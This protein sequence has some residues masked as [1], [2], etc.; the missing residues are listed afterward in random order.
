MS[1]GGRAR[2]RALLLVAPLAAFMA[3][4]FAWPLAS[5]LGVAVRS[6]AVSTALPRTAAAI[7]EWDGA[8]LPALEV[9]AALVDDLRDVDRQTL[10][11]AVGRLNAAVPGFRSL[12]AGT[13][14]AAREVAGPL[15]LRGVDSR[16][17]EAPFWRAIR[18]EA[19]PLTDRNLLAA[20]DLRRDE[21]GGIERV[22]QG[23]SASWAVLRRSFSIAATITAACLAI[24]LPYAVIAARAAGWRRNAMLLAVLLPLWTSLLVRT[25]AWYILLQE[26]GLIND[27]LRGLGL[28]DA[29]LPLIF[30]RLGVVVAMTHVLLPFMV[31]PIFTVVAAIPATLIPAAASLGAGRIQAFARIL[32]PLALPGI[33]SGSLLVFMV[34]IGY[35]ITPALVGGP[36]D[37]MISA[38]IAFYALETANFGMAGALGIVLLCITVILYGLYG[39][40]ART[41]APIAM[42]AP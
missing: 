16:W 11:V 24:G 32:L 27:A 14:E 1:P 15:D 18:A 5:V 8:G 34:S 33:V 23:E 35:Y 31:L 40:L 3:V 22:P 28:V 36:N 17:V 39:R 37:Q 21:A 7:G 30:N 29:P 12:I 4:F 42:R 13:A 26:N 6:D 20:L 9:Q 38:T 10:G 41:G 2:L 19:R 25:A